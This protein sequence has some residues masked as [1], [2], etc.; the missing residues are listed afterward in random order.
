MAKGILKKNSDLELLRKLPVPKGKII[1]AVAL[2][3][4]MGAMWLRLLLRDKGT[5]PSVAGAAVVSEDV[6]G[7][8]G[9]ESAGRI[10][11]IELPVVA[12]RHDVLTR[13]VFT[14]R[15]WRAFRSVGG[16]VIAIG[17]G[18]SG[19]ITADDITKMEGLIKLDGIIASDGSAMVEAFI[20]GK[21]VSIGSK[22]AVEYNNRLL[23]LVVTEIHKNRVV[24]RWE[25]FTLNVKMPQAD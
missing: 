14:T 21:L 9:G 25:K 19:T 17:D 10:S 12:G 24:L 20:D 13:D 22:V 16:A 11:Y 1:V 8:V 5:G 2:V 18:D 23:E 3:A 6:A 4:V 7:V 15:N